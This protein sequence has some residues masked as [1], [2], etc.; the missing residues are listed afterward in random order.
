VKTPAAQLTTAKR[1]EL[2]WYAAGLAGPRIFQHLRPIRRRTKQKLSILPVFILKMSNSRGEMQ[3]YHRISRG[4][5][6]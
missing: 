4:Y 1:K 3:H 6:L 5:Y 2:I